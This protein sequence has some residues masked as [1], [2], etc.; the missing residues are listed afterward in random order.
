MIQKIFEHSEDMELF[1][2]N[3]LQELEENI[4]NPSLD[5]VREWEKITEENVIEIFL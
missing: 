5:S 1:C 3:I 4:D 2:L